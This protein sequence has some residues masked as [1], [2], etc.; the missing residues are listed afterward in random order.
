MFLI[1]NK[2]P[3]KY[4]FQ[5][6]FKYKNIYNKSKIK[7][8]LSFLFFNMF[9]Q[10]FTY[11]KFKYNRGPGRSFAQRALKIVV[12][13]LHLIAKLKFTSRQTHW[14]VQLAVIIII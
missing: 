13:S 8:E 3:E 7:V 11:F 4:I 5:K 10:Y 9:I 12:P 1:K 14:N 6:Q 2:R